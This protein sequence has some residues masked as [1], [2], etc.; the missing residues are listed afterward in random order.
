MTALNLIL[1]LHNLPETTLADKSVN[2]IPIQEFLSWLDDVVMILIIVSVIV[3]LPLLLPVLA[4]LLVLSLLGPP[5][6]L[7]VVDLVDV[8]VSLYKID[9]QFPE[10]SGAGVTVAGL[11]TAPRHGHQVTS[12][13]S[14]AGVVEAHH[15]RE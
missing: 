15:L 7:G 10:R 1:S 13:R 11:H 4:A 14:G 8:F 5:L 9:R 12:V 6:L 2:F 3:Q